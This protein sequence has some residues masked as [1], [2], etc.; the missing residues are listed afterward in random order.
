VPS[1][2]D[3]HTEGVKL[4]WTHADV[5]KGEW[6]SGSYGRIWKGGGVKNLIFCGRHKWMPPYNTG[7]NRS[8][9]DSPLQSEGTTTEE[10]RFCLVVRS[11][12]T[13]RKPRSLERKERRPGILMV[14]QQQ[15][16]RR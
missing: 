9:K 16:L 5:H 10:A 1:I 8:A 4:R 13:M 6:A 7:Y 3:V 12:G 2:Y 11:K 14:V 15:R